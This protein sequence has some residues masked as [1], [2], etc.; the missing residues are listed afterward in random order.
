MTVRKGRR[1]APLTVKAT[2]EVMTVRDLTL[3]LHC[4]QGTVYRLIKEHNL[5]AF[6]LGRGWRFRREQIDEW[7]ADRT[8]VVRHDR[9]QND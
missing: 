6:R 1:R 3:Y 9:D 8:Q 4:D 2:A 5:P 7:I